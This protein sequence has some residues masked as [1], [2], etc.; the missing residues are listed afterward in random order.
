[1]IK[2]AEYEGKK[3]WY[4][5]TT[6]EFLPDTDWKK[7]EHEGKR[8]IFNS[9]TSEFIEGN[10]EEKSVGEKALHG[11]EVFAS[12]ANKGIAGMLGMPADVGNLALSGISAIPPLVGGPNLGLASEEPFMGSEWFKRRILPPPVK[13]ETTA[14]KYLEVAG[15]QVPGLLPGVAIASKTGAVMPAIKEAAKFGAGATAAGGTVRAMGTESPLATVLAEIV[16]GVGASKI[17][18]TI[19]SLTDLFPKVAH[20][21]SGAK[22]GAKNWVQGLAENR[23]AKAIAE[24]RTKGPEPVTTQIEK[25][26]DKWRH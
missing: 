18:Y 25:N 15:E 14:E 21:L 19:K 26:M 11:A 13:P 10:V 12:G 3:G 2:A 22:E 17:P 5:D 8:G 16:G 23:A 7:A 9:A 20:P 24:T 6:S 1:M 4:D